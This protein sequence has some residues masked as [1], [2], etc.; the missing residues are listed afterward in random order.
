[1]EGEEGDA[2][3]GGLGTPVLIDDVEMEKRNGG[4]AEHAF[5]TVRIEW[6]KRLRSTAGRAGWKR[7]APLRERAIALS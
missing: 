2:E 1:M 5:G 3:G 7:C 6:N 4:T